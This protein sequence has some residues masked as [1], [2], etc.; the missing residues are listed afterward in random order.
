MRTKHNL[1]SNVNKVRSDNVESA[2]VSYAQATA[3]NIYT[4]QAKTNQEIDLNIPNS[5]KNLITQ[6]MT[7]IDTLLNL[8]GLFLSLGGTGKT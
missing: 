8:I 5:N 4:T 1:N 3:G 6:L 2:N 7:K